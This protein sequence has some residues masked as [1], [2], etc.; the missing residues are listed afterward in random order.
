MCEQLHGI[1]IILPQE[2]MYWQSLIVLE[3]IQ[4]EKLQSRSECVWVVQTEGICNVLLTY[5]AL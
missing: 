4:R 2:K 1:Y 5:S 3:V